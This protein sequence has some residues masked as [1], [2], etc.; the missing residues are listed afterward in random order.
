MG[1][2][3]LGVSTLGVNRETVRAL[4]EDNDE[5]KN[6]TMNPTPKLEVSQ[7][8]AADKETDKVV[9]IEEDTIQ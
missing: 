9:D 3:E 6:D 7:S 4:K 1:A 2:P 5:E 8:V